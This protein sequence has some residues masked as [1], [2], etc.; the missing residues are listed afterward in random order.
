MEEKNNEA[1]Q[2]FY[3]EYGHRLKQVEDR[4]Q[5]LSHWMDTCNVQIGE[6]RDGIKKLEKEIKEI[7]EMFEDQNE[8]HWQSNEIKK[9]QIEKLW[10][11]MHNHAAL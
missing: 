7:T 3:A 5:P 1:I 11:C 4:H 8:K 2:R 6:L 9:D 10:E